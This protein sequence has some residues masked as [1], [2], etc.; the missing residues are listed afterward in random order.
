MN[1]SVGGNTDVRETD[2]FRLEVYDPAGVLLGALPV[3]H[4]VDDIFIN[5]DKIYL[6]D[7]MRGMQFF[8]YQILDK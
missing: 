2:M 4:F 5:G 7:R 3:K 1:V 6:L 8:E